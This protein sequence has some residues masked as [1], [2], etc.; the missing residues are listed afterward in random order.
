MLQLL[1]KEVDSLLFRL[2]S[3][4]SRDTIRFPLEAKDILVQVN[5]CA[6]FGTT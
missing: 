5:M 1:C 4:V 6:L 2:W 3:C